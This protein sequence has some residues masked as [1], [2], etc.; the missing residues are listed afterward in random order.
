MTLFR[1]PSRCPEEYW[2][3]LTDANRWNKTFFAHGYSQRRTNKG[4]IYKTLVKF[5][6]YGDLAREIKVVV[7]DG[8]EPS[9]A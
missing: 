9:K 1:R 2:P 3:S 7:G 8:F 6:K 5:D 4:R